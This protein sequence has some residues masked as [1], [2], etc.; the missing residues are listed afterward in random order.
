MTREHPDIFEVEV[1]GEAQR[2]PRTQYMVIP[3]GKSKVGEK[4]RTC[5]ATSQLQNIFRVKKTT[6]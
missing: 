6:E 2:V 4:S 1:P 5:P 3:T